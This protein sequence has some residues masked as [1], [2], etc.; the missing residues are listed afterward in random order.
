MKII[1][2]TKVNQRLKKKFLK[3]LIIH[4]IKKSFLKNI[5]DSATFGHYTNYWD[6]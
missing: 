4:I 3:K 5:E 6:N 2:P 1:N